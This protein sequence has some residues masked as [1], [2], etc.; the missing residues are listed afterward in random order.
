MSK[1]AIVI[2]A[3]GLVGNELVKLLCKTNDISEVV[4]IAR[5][6]LV[7]N[8][9]KLK[10]HIVD[11]EKLA[12]HSHLFKG[13]VLF[14][15]LGT[16]KKKAKTIEAQRRVDLNYQY[17]IAEMAANNNIQDYLLVSSSGANS[18]SRSPY[19]KMKGELEEKV[20]ALCFKRISILQPS[21]LLG[22]RQE[23]RI[24]ETLASVILP[25]LC[26]LPWL[27]RYR[28]ISGQQVAHKLLDVYQNQT[29]HQAIYTLDELFN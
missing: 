18:N 7:F 9:A 27:K 17:L 20:K 5:R 4:V 14:S 13:D 22:K 12:E 19:L 16:T 29:E 21:L 25:T 8:H 23:F 3:T 6:E 28:P 2:G 24:I 15:C 26:K 1:K 11:F 10:C